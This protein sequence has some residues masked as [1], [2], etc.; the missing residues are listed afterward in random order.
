MCGIRPF[1]NDLPGKY[2]CRDLIVAKCDNGETKA[3]NST[4]NVAK[5]DN[6]EVKVGGPVLMVAK[7]DNGETEADSPAL[8][9]A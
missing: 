5:R 1:F 3:G 8:I 6:G 4:V 7:R 9:V 2:P